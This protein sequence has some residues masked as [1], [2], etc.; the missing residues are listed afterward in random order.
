LDGYKDVDVF[1][2]VWNPEGRAVFHVGTYEGLV[3]D[4]EGMGVQVMEVSFEE[5][6]EARCFLR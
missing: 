2:K 4:L 6:Y 5:G 1:F 3:E